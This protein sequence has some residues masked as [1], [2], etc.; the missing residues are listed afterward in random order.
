MSSATA[1]GLSEPVT[2]ERLLSSTKRQLT[3]IAFPEPEQ[4]GQTC[5]EQ[6]IDAKENRF[7]SSLVFTTVRNE[8]MKCQ[9]DVRASWQ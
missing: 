4:P 9:V 6:E 1:G 5:P 7:E 2:L 8:K 3:R